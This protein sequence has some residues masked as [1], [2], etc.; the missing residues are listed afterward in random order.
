MKSEEILREEGIVTEIKSNQIRIDLIK[1][2][3]CDN[4]STKD[5]CYSGRR[6]FLLVKYD[7]EFKVGDLVVI[8]VYGKDVLKIV[9]LLFGIPL[10]LLITSLLIFYFLINPKK[11]FI[12]IISSFILLG[13]YYLILSLYLKNSGNFYQMK[14]SKKQS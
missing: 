5:F 2:S 12:A 8:E 11:E 7:G 3:E 4:C 6:D 9:F 14:I 10:L 1:T 13:F